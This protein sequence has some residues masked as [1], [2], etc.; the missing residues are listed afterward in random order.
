MPATQ[1]VFY[2]DLHNRGKEWGGAELMDTGPERTRSTSSSGRPSQRRG[3]LGW[4]ASL[5]IIILGIGD[6]HDKVSPGGEKLEEEQAGAGR[7]LGGSPVGLD[8]RQ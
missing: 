8:H 6:V 5:N 3:H 7:Q 1:P 4:G 2:K